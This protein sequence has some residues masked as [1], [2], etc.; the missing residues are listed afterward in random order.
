MK[1]QIIITSLLC[2]LTVNYL[3][4]LLISEYE[5]TTNFHLHFLLITLDLR[6]Q[7]KL[8]IR[9]DLIGSESDMTA[10]YSYWQTVRNIGAAQI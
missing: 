6:L 7:W 3:I 5:S 4:T 9:F 8:K 1:K 10:R 2:A